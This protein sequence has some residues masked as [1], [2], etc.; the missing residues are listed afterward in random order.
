MNKVELQTERD[1]LQ[2]IFEDY[3]RDGEGQ[4]GALDRVFF[5]G[6]KK[7][8]LSRIAYMDHKIAWSPA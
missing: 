5:E 6:R 1:R 3:E 2:I 8:L 7:H 4:Q